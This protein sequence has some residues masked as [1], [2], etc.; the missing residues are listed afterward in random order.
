MVR[1]KK[2][3]VVSIP[4]S[5]YRELIEGTALLKA[6]LDQL[7][8]EV[9]RLKAKPGHETHWKTKEGQW[10]LYELLE[11]DHLLN[12]VRQLDWYEN[13]RA[14]HV[15]RECIRRWGHL[16][17]S[18]N[19]ARQVVCSRAEAWLQKRDL[20]S[21]GTLE[22]LFNNLKCSESEDVI[23]VIRHVIRKSEGI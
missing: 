3:D 6:Q 23:K 10:I 18:L 2:K 1:T 14:P 5:E 11:D 22:V 9:A 7:Q 19:M 12:I 15:K 4:T 16:K 13:S 8:L 20:P 17:V 21:E